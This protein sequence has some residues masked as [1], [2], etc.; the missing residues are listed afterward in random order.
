MVNSESL[1]PL[2]ST[3][4]ILSGISTRIDGSITIKLDINP[5]QRELVSN[6]MSLWA[7][8]QRDLMVVFLKD[9]NAIV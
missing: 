2:G 1:R 8:S 9:E 7:E 6:L 5:D 4:A 3:Q